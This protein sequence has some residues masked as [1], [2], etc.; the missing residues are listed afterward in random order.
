MKRLFIFCAAALLAVS[1]SK[2]A[3]P[4]SESAG[5]D[6]LQGKYQVDLTSLV[7]DEF[8]EEDE[9]AAKQA[10]TFFLSKMH[11]TLE[12]KSD[13]IA[14]DIS[15]ALG[16]FLHM[17]PHGDDESDSNEVEYKI[18]NDSLLSTRNS[19]GEWEDAGVLRKID[20]TYDNLQWVLERDE[21]GEEKILL[22]HKVE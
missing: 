16:E 8:D 7:A 20:G 14:M 17:L 18:T 21:D 5:S 19:D 12:F 6:G 13:R 15:G 4:Q 10:A 1:C 2:S 3:K 9:A 22:L 11:F